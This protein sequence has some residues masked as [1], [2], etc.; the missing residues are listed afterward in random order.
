MIK[1]DYNSP[2]YQSHQLADAFYAQAWLIVH[3]GLIEDHGL[4]P[5]D[6][7]IPDAAELARASGRSHACR[8]W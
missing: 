8:V 7:Q 1:I 3:Y 2:E 6:L 4:R 5:P